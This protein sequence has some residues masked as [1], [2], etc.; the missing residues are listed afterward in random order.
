MDV[1]F[2]VNALDDIISKLESNFVGSLHIQDDQKSEYVS[3]EN[4]I[5]NCHAGEGHLCGCFEQEETKL[6]MKCLKECSTFPYPDMIL[7]SSSSDKEANTSLAESL[8]EQSPHQSYSCSAS[9]PVS[10]EHQC[11]CMLFLFRKIK[12]KF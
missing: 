12:S 9:L 8:S 6:E 5:G 4:N 10:S 11:F 7:P 2:P 3:E 1:H